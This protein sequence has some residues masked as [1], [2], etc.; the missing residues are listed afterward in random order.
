MLSIERIIKIKIKLKQF[1]IKFLIK[2]PFKLA[3]KH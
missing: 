1:L 3:E 2:S